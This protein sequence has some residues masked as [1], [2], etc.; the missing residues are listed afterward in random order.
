MEV[1]SA[2]LA[3]AARV[4]SGKLYVHGGGWD[5]L[6]VLTTPV[7]HP[8]LSF[9]AVLDIGWNEA[10]RPVQLGVDLYDEDEQMVFAGNRGM[11][12]IGHPPDSTPGMNFVVPWQMTFT[13]LR[14]DKEGIYTFRLMA[15]SSELVP[16][17]SVSPGSRCPCCKDQWM[18]GLLTHSC[19][20]ARQT[21]AVA[22]ASAN[23]WRGSSTDPEVR[24]RLSG[25]LLLPKRRSQYPFDLAKL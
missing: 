11:L 23:E 14:L 8:T 7:V 12:Q 5:T 16:C 1:T 13:M 24:T 22:A 9:V 25:S 3:D 4:E 20:C 10:F 6:F 19:G 15:D 18:R 2:L 17:A 21:G